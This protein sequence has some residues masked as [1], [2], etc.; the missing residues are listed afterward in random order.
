VRSNTRGM[1]RRQN[2][3][4]FR[5]DLA[6]G[7]TFT[8]DLPKQHRGEVTD[9]LYVWN[10]RHMARPVDRRDLP[11]LIKEF[12]VDCLDGDWIAQFKRK[13]AE[14]EAKKEPEPEPPPETEEV[15]HDV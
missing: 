7:V 12:G 5:R 13:K 10:A 15:E 1:K 6:V 9:T 2:P 8:C 4:A 3:A 14:R 11:G